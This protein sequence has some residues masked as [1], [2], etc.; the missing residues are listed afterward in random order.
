MHRGRGLAVSWRGRR[1]DAPRVKPLN[2]HVLP[3][4]PLDRRVRYRSIMSSF[5]I[6]PSAMMVTAKTLNSLLRRE[7]WARERLS[8]HAGKSVRLALGHVNLNVAIRS[9]GLVQASDATIVPDVILAVPVS[10]WAQLPAAL[11]SGDPS[12]I[13]ALMRIQGDAGLAQV[14]SDLARDLRWDVEDQL[15]DVVGDAAA[16]RILGTG[17]TLLAG[18]RDA[19]R[20]L[21]GNM[22]EYLSHESGMLLDRSSYDIWAGDIRSALQ[23]LDRL[24]RLSGSAPA[25]RTGGS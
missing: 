24:E 20:R 8:R 13:A 2:F 15:S 9:D 10:N 7:S 25:A 16:V 12:R 3:S 21:S 5:P 17:K 11:R 4:A 6:F 23:R 1:A 22:A 14:V 19:A 18:M